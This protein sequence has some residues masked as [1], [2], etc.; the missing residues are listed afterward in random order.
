MPKSQARTAARPAQ[1]EGR[2]HSVTLSASRE[3]SIIRMDEFIE[4]GKKNDVN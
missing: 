2:R 4:Q 3:G 1:K